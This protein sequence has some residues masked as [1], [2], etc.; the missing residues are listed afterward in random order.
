M[1]QYQVSRGGGV[2]HF[3]VHARKAILGGLSPA[4][5]RNIPPLKYDYVYRLVR[6]FPDV[7]FTLN[8]GINAYEEV[9]FCFG[10][11]VSLQMSWAVAR[12]I[13]LD[14]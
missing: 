11:S 8:G 7:D 14:V 12:P 5:N 9:R 6:D 1:L 10:L 13:P 3:I 2:D 4:Q